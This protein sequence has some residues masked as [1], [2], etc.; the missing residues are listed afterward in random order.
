[1]PDLLGV[2]NP[3][4]GFERDTGVRNAPL[5]PQDPQIQN[6]VD[7][8]RVGRADGRTD[9]QN[10]ASQ[11][12]QVRYD[13]NF[14]TFFQRLRETPNL[15]QELSKLF[16]MR[17]GLQVRSGM[18]EGI[19]EELAQALKMLQMDPSQML[20]FMKGQSESG[21]R[22]SGALFALLRN[23]Y[24]KASSDTVRA[25]ILQFLKTYSD[26]SSTS[27][28]EG[29]LLRNLRGMA[30]SMPSS[31][32]EKLLEMMARL[33]NGISAGDRQGNIQL[34]KGELFPYMSS[35]VERTHDMGTPRSLLSQMALDLA[36]YEG[37]SRENLLEAFHRMSAYGT[38]RTQLGEI[39]DDTL[40]N[41]LRAARFSET[42]PANQFA[43]HLSAA[44]A[45]ALRG[46]GSTEIQQIFQ[47]LVTAM[48]IN[49]SVYLPLNH[50]ILPWQWDDKML[51]SE[52]WVDPD[53][54]NRTETGQGGRTIRF[55]FKIDVQSVGLFDVVLTHWDN[56]KVDIRIACPEK[57]AGFSKEIEKTVSKILERNQLK[58][59]EIVV[60]RMDRP[61]TVSEVFPKILER[62][63]GVNVKV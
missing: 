27:H 54:E 8:S 25:D 58:P 36:R 22:F 33:Q 63:S 57:V 48:L 23:A 20:Q 30:N 60:R 18:S 10:A 39:D 34:L 31:W 44:A 17:E 14:S 46:E 55:L 7:P 62:K 52:M 2:T 3:M 53:A 12:S 1:M 26:Y 42:S 47:Q 45:R 56:D 9:Q 19:A 51:F 13:S 24:T 16:S 41:I 4:P 11:D 59:T 28:L 21:T 6:P 61:L 40:M 38:L 32:G 37:G 49:E 5:S 35:Y 50:F 43:D 15:A 29:N